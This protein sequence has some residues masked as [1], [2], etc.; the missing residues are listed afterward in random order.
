[1][2]EVERKFKLTAEHY[3]KIEEYFKDKKNSLH[4][5]H[6]ID[7]IFLPGI[8]SFAQF[9]QGMPVVRLRTVDNET[10]LTY[11][12]SINDGGDTLEHE[13]TIESPGVMRLI[14]LDMDYRQITVVDKIR[15]EY[16][17][18]ELTVML[19]D[20]KELGRFLE[21][22]AMVDKE[23]NITEATSTIMTKA[24]EFDLTEADIEPR[25]YDKLM[26]EQV[27]N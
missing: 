18:G 20:V 2:I 15:T 10:L 26:T 21:I 12:R 1:M 23:E 13:L 25:K 4:I 22:E 27:A 14:L 9:K 5:Q 24:A 16:K 8:D 11:K 3:R 17:D 7:E 6:Q 19:D